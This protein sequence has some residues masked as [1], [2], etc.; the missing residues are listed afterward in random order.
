LFCRSGDDPYHGKNRKK[1]IDWFLPCRGR[2]EYRD[3]R[4]LIFHTIYGDHFGQTAELK[5][6]QDAERLHSLEFNDAVGI[7]SD[8]LQRS[9]FVLLLGC[10]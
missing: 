1:A 5:S 7:I 4:Q 2:A 10:A 3:Y 8:S 6:V 9:V